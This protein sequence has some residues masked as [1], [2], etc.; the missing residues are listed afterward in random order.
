MI[1]LK[2]LLTALKLNCVTILLCIVIQLVFEDSPMLI[3]NIDFGDVFVS[4]AVGTM[5][6]Y[7]IIFLGNT[8][9]GKG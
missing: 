1:D 6:I 5:N 8:V 9:K 4:V 7:A 3:E 2:R